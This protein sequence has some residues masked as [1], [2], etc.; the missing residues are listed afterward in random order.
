M[1]YGGTLSGGKKY[2]SSLPHPACCHAPQCMH[3]R[4]GAATIHDLAVV[5][6]ARDGRDLQ[7]VGEG[8]LDRLAAYV[9]HLGERPHG[10]VRERAQQRRARHRHRVAEGETV[11][12]ELQ[13]AGTSGVCTWRWWMTYSVRPS[14]SRTTG[15]SAWVRDMTHLPRMTATHHPLT[16]TTP[17]ARSRG[18]PPRQAPPPSS[19]L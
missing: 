9:Q 6:V 10:R 15:F 7:C 12:T 14:P 8:R 11:R 19:A 3:A 1:L 4:T 16:R 5:H 2:A 17:P 18:R 13:P